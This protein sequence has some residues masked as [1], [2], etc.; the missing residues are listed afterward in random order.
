MKVKVSIIVPVYKVEKYLNRC[1]DSIINQTYKNIEIILVDDESPDNC[2]KMCEKYAKKDQRIKTYHKKNGGLS[3]ARNYGL[4]YAKGEYI[5]YVDS[6]DYIEPKMIEILVNAI[7][8]NNA[9][10]AMCGTKVVGDY[11]TYNNKWFDNDLVLNKEEALKALLENRIITSHAWNKLYRKEIIKKYPWPK[12]RLYEDIRIMH[13]VFKSCQKIAIC[14][15]YLYDYYQRED[16]ICNNKNLANEFEYVD[17]FITRYEDI[18]NDS[19]EYEEI[20]Y[21]QACIAISNFLMRNNLSKEDKNKYASTIN[22]Y[23]QMLKKIK[24]WKNKNLGK[25]EKLIIKF[26]LL[27]KTNSNKIYLLLKMK[28]TNNG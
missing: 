22:A 25:K 1:V 9:D 2:G 11:S 15:E 19:K 18:K 12:G 16:S 23:L 13:N 27:F 6:D 28:G 20:C 21:A 26:T 3:D 5:A 7:E 4:K 14:K 24:V 8:K 10:I 17:A